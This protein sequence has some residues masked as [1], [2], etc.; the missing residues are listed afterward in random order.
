MGNTL[1]G[2]SERARQRTGD[3]VDL[4]THYSDVLQH[5]IPARVQYVFA[6]K[7]DGPKRGD[8]TAAKTRADPCVIDVTTPVTAN[9][10][11]CIRTV[12]QQLA[13]LLEVH[14]P[15]HTA[16]RVCVT[17]QPVAAGLLAMLLSEVLGRY[18]HVDDLA[19]VLPAAAAV[20]AARQAPLRLPP[21]NNTDQQ[22]RRLRI[23]VPLEL[24]SV[25]ELVAHRAI[26]TSLEV[27]DVTTVGG[28]G[29]P[30]G[31]GTAALCPNLRHLRFTVHQPEDAIR[32]AECAFRLA[33]TTLLRWLDI[34]ILDPPDGAPGLQAILDAAVVTAAH[35]IASTAP[36]LRQF[37][38]VVGEGDG[39]T[40]VQPPVAADVV[41][42]FLALNAAAKPHRARIVVDARGFGNVAAGALERI[43]RGVATASDD[44]DVTVYVRNHAGDTACVRRDA[45]TT[46]VDRV[47]DRVW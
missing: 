10:A 37:L 14:A 42:G 43:H 23:D 26:R 36:A 34:R 33:P 32:V 40:T 27:L 38:V 22:L 16:V 19:L 35:R 13:R 41:V 5:Q 6:T 18:P 29:G 4:A 20:A 7:C 30:W 15:Y 45:I 25:V 47:P 9:P 11:E 8:T 17:W 21:P 28:C 2:A 46:G 44:D 3:F 12:Q 31:G 24:A 1:L 39:T